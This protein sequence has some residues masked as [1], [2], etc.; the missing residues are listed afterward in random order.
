MLFKK[1]FGHQPESSTEEAAGIH[2]NV[3]VN[4]EEKSNGLTSVYHLVVLDESGSMSCVTKQTISGCNETIQTIRMMQENNRDTQ[5]HY[6]SIYLFESGRS[7]Y[8]IHNLPVNEAKD[9]T[10]QDYRPNGCTPLFD[11]LGFTLT[12]LKEI[13]DQPDTLGYVTI[14]TDGEENSSRKYSLSQVR[15]LIDEL[16]KKDVIFSFIGAN[17]DAAEYAKSLNIGNS[18]QFVQDDE[19]TRAMWE[20]ERRGKMRSGAKMSFMKKFALEEFDCCFSACENS[21]HYYKEEVD[22]ERVTPAF[23]DKLKKNEIFVFGSNVNGQHNGGAA[24][25]AV[26]HFGAIIGQAEGLQ[27]QSYAVP[28]DGVTEE[29]FYQAVCRFCDF[30]QG[31]PELTF[32]VTAVGCGHAGYNPY[33]VAPMFRNVAKLRNVKFPMEFW[34]FLM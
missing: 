10:H 6:V 29:E 32:Y 1:L 14:I 33:L 25:Y 26:A 17:I 12:E 11:A 2:E 19:G 5:I 34:D 7:S 24:G 4:K 27:G 8:I 13:M 18:M 22:F 30:A 9:I 20:R 15:E 31:H 23:V 21:G 16:K 3:S 28:T